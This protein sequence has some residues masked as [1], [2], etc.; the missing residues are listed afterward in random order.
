[1][2]AAKTI[3]DMA[4]GETMRHVL[5]R[6]ADVTD[7]E[8]VLLD[9]W[10]YD[11]YARRP[12]AA[13]LANGVLQPTD[14]DL[15]CFLS[16]LAD[17]K[18]VVNIPKY[19]PRRASTHREGERVLSKDNR[20]GRITGITANKSAFSFSV[21][22]QDQNVISSGAEGDEVGA[23][24]NF[25]LVD[26]DG[27]WHDGWKCIEFMPS[28]KENDF[29]TDRKLWTDNQVVFKNFVHP[30]RWIS[31]YGQYYFLTKALIQRLED[32][33]EFRREAEKRMLAAGVRFPSSGEGSPQAWPH[34]EKTGE[35]KPIKVRAFE[36]EVDVPWSGAFGWRVGLD[37]Q[38]ELIANADRIRRVKNDILP[39]LRFATRATELA[40]V[41]VGASA[42]SLPV[43]MTGAIWEEGYVQKGKRIAWT[44]LVHTRE[45]PAEEGFALRYRL[46]EK[47]ERV[48][49]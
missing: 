10:S 47:T 2:S 48:A 3:L 7:L 31:F 15:A 23:P 5:D 19:T 11:L 28:A 9:H 37:P 17:R 38:R 39:R 27:T 46:Y 35:D 21:R 25:M 49:A 6:T 18:A 41:N 44:R 12:G 14:L 13:Y 16:A 40:F 22:I 8:R 1:M 32:E 4:T 24:R 29:L 42:R 33:N 36:C 26:V 34:T 30:N 45:W 43:W 20:H